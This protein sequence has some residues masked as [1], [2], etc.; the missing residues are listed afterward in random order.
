MKEVDLHLRLQEDL[1]KVV[2]PSSMVFPVSMTEKPATKKHPNGL[3]V[4]QWEPIQIKGL[5]GI[6]QAIVSYGIHYPY[7]RELLNS[8]A[9]ANRVTPED[10]S[11]LI[12]TLL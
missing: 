6:K 3:V 11:Q 4:Y 7:V 1:L 10:W 9:S 8:L 12:S 2:M 5:K